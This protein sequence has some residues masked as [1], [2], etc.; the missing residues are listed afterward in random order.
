MCYVE[1]LIIEVFNVGEVFNIGTFDS[2][3]P[4]A[5]IK[6]AFFDLLFVFY[7]GII[8]HNS[9]FVNRFCGIF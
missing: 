7:D 8:T 1:I 9:Y 2:S 4:S 5:G 3:R 6:Y